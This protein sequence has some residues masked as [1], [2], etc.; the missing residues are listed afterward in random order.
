MKPGFKTSQF[1]TAAGTVAAALAAGLTD[2]S[3][4]VRAAAMLAIG[5]VGGM[6]QLTLKKTR[7]A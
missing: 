1:I 2:E 4:I 6:Y 5:F 3:D 7:V